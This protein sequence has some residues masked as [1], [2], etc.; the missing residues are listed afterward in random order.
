VRLSDELARLLERRS[1]ARPVAVVRMV[2]GLAALARAYETSRIL[3]RYFLP[4]TISL[5]HATWLPE[6]TERGAT[7][8]LATWVAAAL[9]FAVGWRTRAAGSALAVIC[10]YIVLL[11]EQLY[12]NH[13]YLLAMLCVLLVLADAGAVWSIDAWRQ[14]RRREASLIASDN[15][16][17]WPVFLLNTQVSSV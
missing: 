1:D 10:L 6:V 14:R 3:G 4:S 12:S 17:A 16:P 9:L 15:V 5:P 8:L 13:L 7:F 2:I 11:D